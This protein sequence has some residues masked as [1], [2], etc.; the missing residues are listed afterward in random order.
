MT[1]RSLFTFTIFPG[2]LWCLLAVG[3]F[4]A[5]GLFT[6]SVGLAFTI[7]FLIGHIFLFAGVT[8]LL[9]LPF[10]FIGPRTLQA[11]CVGWGSVGSLFLTVDSVVF[12]QYRFHINRAMLELFLGPA[13]QDIFVFPTAMWLLVAAGIL[14]VIVLETG[15]VYAAK[16]KPL[17]HKAIALISGLWLLC[18]LTFNGLYA[19]GRFKQISSVISQRKAL[20]LAYPMSANRR[21]A[22]WGFTPG[23]NSY[24]TPGKGALDYPLNPLSCQT[25]KPDTNIL[26]V[27]VDAWRA[28]VLNAEVM[29][30]L[31]A[32]LTNPGMTTFTQH[33]SGGN[34]TAGGVFSLFY[35]L[36]HSY[37]DDFT[38]QNRPPLLLS[39][40]LQAGY[41]PAI[42]ASS[43]LNSPAF[44][45]NIFATVENLR[46]GSSGNTPWQ[47]DEEAVL[48]FENFLQ[49][50]NPKQPFFGFIFLDAPHGYSY[51]PEA[52]KFTPAKE[53]NYL[54]LTN[55]TDPLPYWN[56]YQNS[57][58]FVDQ[59]I[60]R[61]WQALAQH[62]LLKNTLV[63]ITADHGQ[64]LNDSHRNF[65][66]HNSNF[67]DYQTH[68]PLLV[69]DPARPTATRAD[70]RTTHYD[71][72]TT[73]L[74][75]VFGCQNPPQ[76][77]TIGYDLFD[78]TPQPF[79]IFAGYEEKAVRMGDVILVFNHFDAFSQYGPHLEPVTARTD[80][81][82]LKEALKTFSRFYK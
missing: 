41:A 34:S 79:S 62:G 61:V 33:L 48:G 72:A 27:L 45:R 43:K 60:E 74:R 69:Y 9:C 22:K 36:P 23:R 19:W 73:L 37:W 54:L 44:N 28:D 56:Q 1:R 40:P 82:T 66:G 20:P 52:K 7:T 71:I 5:N 31:S 4:R 11:A 17:S 24:Q 75:R 57:V 39:Q 58:Y 51:P 26:L 55:A 50:R 53:I 67:T 38:G 2:V 78:P 65:W 21:L 63:V 59:L 16:R 32:R 77:Y 10:S 42:F 35:G 64:E 49:T 6:D 18:F 13:R 30:R 70:Y 3:Y 47:R 46:L 29:P 76:D 68:V 80:A 8:G 15:L 25:A 12:A 81:N 14:G